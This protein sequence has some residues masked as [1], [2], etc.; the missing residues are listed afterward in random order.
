MESGSE[1]VAYSGDTGWFDGLPEQVNGSHLFICECTY[2]SFDF[3]YHLNHRELPRMLEHIDTGAK[4]E[5]DVV[6]GHEG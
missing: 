5:P 6:D 4:R 3:E 2:H 1:R